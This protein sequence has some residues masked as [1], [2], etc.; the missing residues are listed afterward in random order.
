LLG[1]QDIRT[2]NPI[3]S[4]FATV[5]LRHRKTKSPG[6]R[7]ACLTMVF[8]LMESASK[9][10][11]ALNG[12]WACDRRAGA[13]YGPRVRLEESAAQHAPRKAGAIRKGRCETSRRNWRGLQIRPAGGWRYCGGSWRRCYRFTMGRDRADEES[14][15]FVH[16]PRIGWQR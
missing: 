10:W 12:S 11:R 14:S 15:N 8:K 4:T 6:S 2:T 7:M 3:E 9:T 16:P 5:R 13:N 1:A